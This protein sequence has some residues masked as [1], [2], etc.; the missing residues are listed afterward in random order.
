MYVFKLTTLFCLSLPGMH[1]KR[2]CTYV[3]IS[4]NVGK[5]S[6]AYGLEY[7]SHIFENGGWM[8]RERE[9]KNKLNKIYILPS[10]IL[11]ITNE[12]K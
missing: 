6:K 2:V 4:E 3:E 8:V 11:F 10:V 5:N 9:L 1:F 7:R 12:M